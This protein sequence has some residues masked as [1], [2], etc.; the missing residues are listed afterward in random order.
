MR[1]RS[2]LEAMALSE[3]HAEIRLLVAHAQALPR[4]ALKWA[5]DSQPLFDVVGEAGDLITVLELSARFQPHM[6]L[7]DSD[8]PGLVLPDS[9]QELMEVVPE[10]NVLILAASGH[11]ETL[12][13]AIQ[14]GARG[15][16][17]TEYRLPALAQAVQAAARGEMIVPR[18]MLRGLLDGILEDHF[19]RERAIR[20][21][22]TLSDREKAVLRLLLEGGN[23]DTI[24]EALFISPQTARTHIQNILVKMRVH[25]RLEAVALVRKHGILA[26]LI[27]RAA[28]AR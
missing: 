26:E 17:T 5:L 21:V 16:V 23:N 13:R 24:A 27:E 28:P 25:S 12:L 15:Y 6:I 4:K 20:L 2:F 3:L 9:L 19:E 8:L 14:G 10:S 1:L 18:R 22:S 7:V 11:E